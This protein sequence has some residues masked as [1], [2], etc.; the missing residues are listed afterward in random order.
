MGF[1]TK[2]YLM[3]GF[4]TVL[5]L[6]EYYFKQTE[7]GIAQN[8]FQLKNQNMPSSFVIKSP[9]RKNVAT[10]AHAARLV[11]WSQMKGR[12]TMDPKKLPKRIEKYLMEYS[13]FL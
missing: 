1:L 8:T 9:L 7:S 6:V 13:Y 11:F 12:R 3:P 2:E 4:V 10:L 5:D